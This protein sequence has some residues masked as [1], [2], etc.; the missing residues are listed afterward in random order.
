MTDRLPHNLLA[1]FQPRPPLRYLPPRD[2]APEERTTAKVDGVASFLTAL[3]EKKEE[4]K[5]KPWTESHL[6]RTTR[7]KQEKQ[8]RQKWLM[9]DGF[10]SLWKPEEDP[11]IRGRFY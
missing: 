2:R 7:E 10:A 6:E 1:L 9:S 4:D 5:D 11:N 3:Q 8:V